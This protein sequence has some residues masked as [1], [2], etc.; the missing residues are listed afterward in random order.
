MDVPRFPFEDSLSMS[1]FIDLFEERAIL[2]GRLGQ[3]QV[4]LKLYIDTLLDVYLILLK[5]LLRTSRNT[6]PCSS[7]HGSPLVSSIA[8]KED[9]REINYEVVIFD[10]LKNYWQRIDLAQIKELTDETNEYLF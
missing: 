8:K 4:A 10:I 9:G 6:S 7:S 5:L 3:H 2:L 1:S